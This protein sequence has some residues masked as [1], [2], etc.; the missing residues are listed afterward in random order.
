[1]KLKIS[2]VFDGLMQPATEEETK[3]LEEDI[4]INGV[5][6]ALVVW[7][8]TKI[9]I[10]GHRRYRA[11]T[12]VGRNF[13]VLLMDFDTEAEAVV[14]ALKH[15]LGRRNIDAANKKLLA[16]KLYEMMKKPLGFNAHSKV[17]QPDT[18]SGKTAERVGEMTGMSPASVARAVEFKKGVDAAPEEDRPAI[19]AGQKKL[20]KP[21]PVKPLKPGEVLFHDKDFKSDWDIMYRWI[22]KLGRAYGL[23][24]GDGTIKDD[25]NLTGLRRKLKDW[26]ED[27][28]ETK[29]SYDKRRQEQK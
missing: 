13:N 29:K 25:T 28:K 6:D 21:T 10:E 14:W 12:K 19:L 26:L 2:P 9:L 24:N 5:R 11:A 23:L 20:P 15:A 4:R 16:A 7:R 27:F 18:P 3:L 8:Q 17:S 1:M 22:D